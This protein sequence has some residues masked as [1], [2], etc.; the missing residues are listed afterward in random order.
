MQILPCENFIV[1]GIFWK[2]WPTFINLFGKAQTIKKVFQLFL[3]TKKEIAKKQAKNKEPKNWLF[4][5]GQRFLKIAT[6]KIK[7]IF[8]FF[9]FSKNKIFLF[10]VA[11][12]LIGPKCFALFSLC[13]LTQFNSFHSKFICSLFANLSC[14]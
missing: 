7:N 6:K 3:K 14:L 13:V 1:M 11:S 12:F 2:S 10:I 4:H 9:F 8:D 5:W